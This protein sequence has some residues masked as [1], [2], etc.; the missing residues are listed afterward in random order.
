MNNKE[1]HNSNL[2]EEM[3]ELKDELNQAQQLLK[4]YEDQNSKNGQILEKKI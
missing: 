4:S 3:K 2:E 1:A